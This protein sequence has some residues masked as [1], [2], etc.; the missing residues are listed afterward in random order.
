MFVAPC[1]GLI[2]SMLLIGDVSFCHRNSSTRVCFMSRQGHEVDWHMRAWGWWSEVGHCDRIIFG[3]VYRET[4]LGCKLRD[5]SKKKHLF[6]SCLLFWAIIQ[7][8]LLCSLFITP[9]RLS[10]SPFLL[11]SLMAGRFFFFF[12]FFF[13]SPVAP[14]FLLE[15]EN[16]SLQEIPHVILASLNH[17]PL[18]HTLYLLPPVHSNLCSKENPFPFPLAVIF[19]S[20][21][22]ASLPHVSYSLVA[23]MDICLWINHSHVYGNEVAGAH[24]T[25][26]IYLKSNSANQLKT[27]RQLFFLDYL[28]YIN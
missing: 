24:H 27:K 23:I 7:L 25:D 21:H 8:S 1:R 9:R 12:F 26:A 18:P 10:C 3:R 19:V 5:F 14:H 11:F 16:S 17:I 6:Y 2:Q 15:S 20:V 4:R 28:K 13:T 22:I